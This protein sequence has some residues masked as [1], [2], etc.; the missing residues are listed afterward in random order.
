MKP[1]L[2]EVWLLNIVWL[3]ICITDNMSKKRQSGFL[4]ECVYKKNNGQGKIFL[5]KYFLK[6]CGYIKK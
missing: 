3:I 5:L 2:K 6:K 4:K 1:W